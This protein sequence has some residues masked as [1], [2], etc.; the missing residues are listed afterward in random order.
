MTIK[1]D[2]VIVDPI[3]VIGLKQSA[4]SLSDYF[5]LGG[6][7]ARTF[8]IDVLKS[9]VSTQPSIITIEDDNDD[10]YATL[11]VD[12]I[13]DTNDAYYKYKCADKMLLM[14]K[15]LDWTSLGTNPTVSQ[16]LNYICNEFSS[17]VPTGLYGLDAPAILDSTMSAR[18][19]L[20][21]LAE[22]QGGYSY[23]DESGNIK[24]VPYSNTSEGSINTED[25]SSYKVGTEHTFTRVAYNSLPAIYRGDETGETVYLNTQNV[26]FSD[27]DNYTIE[28]MVDH[29]FDIIDG[30]SFYNIQVDKCLVLPNIRCGQMISIGGKPTIVQIDWD[31]NGRWNGGYDLQ[32]QVSTEEEAQINNDLEEFKRQVGVIIDRQN[33]Q[34][35]IFATRISA[36]EED[37]IHFQVVPGEVRVTSQEMDP[38]TA[39]TGFKEDGMRIYVPESDKPVAEATVDRF[40][41]N[42]GLGVQDWAIEQNTTGETLLFYRRRQ[43]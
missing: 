39:Y 32:L 37:N 24:I 34:I 36:I 31:Y 8:E 16:V 9:A 7:V 14:N 26:L 22:L 40:N 35:D 25:C 5:K 28:G 2:N 17:T 1:F 43:S 4:H 10:L 15:S 38:P 33:D 21:W 41:C 18:T 11:F 20:G 27:S 13:D 29:I 42:K 12:S 30:F 19:F 6:T 3:N 23:I